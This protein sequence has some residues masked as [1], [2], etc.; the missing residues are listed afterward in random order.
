VVWQIRQRR[1]VALGPTPHVVAIRGHDSIALGALKLN[2]A[3]VLVGP[4]HPKLTLAGSAQVAH[5]LGLATAP[6]EI[7]STLVVK[8]GER[9]R[10][11]EATSPTPN[12]KRRRSDE[13]EDRIHDMGHEEP[14][15]NVIGWC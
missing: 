14:W 11:R 6:N 4:A 2:C 8:R 13:F 3:E 10:D 12:G 5:P 9:S 15:M 7:T 1:E